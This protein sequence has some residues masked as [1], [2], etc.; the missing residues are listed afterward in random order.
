MSKYL[1]Q[2]LRAL[3]PAFSRKAAFGWFI[4]AFAGFVTRNDNYGVSSIV[5]ALWLSPICYQPLL[6]FFHSSAWTAE[7]LMV[8]WRMWLV[9]QNVAHLQGDRIILVGDH[10]KVVKDGR[11]MPEVETLHQDSETGSKPSYFRGHHWACISLLIRAKDKFFGAPLWAEIHRES[12]GEKRS[13]RIINQA[14]AMAQSLENNAYLVL[15]AFFAAGPVFLTAAH[16][17][18]QLLILTRAKK[19]VV[20]Y[21]VPVKEDD[22]GPGRPRQYGEKLKLMELFDSWPD[23]FK[24]AQSLVYGKVEDVRYLILDLIWKPVKGKLRFILI[25]SS[26]G[27]IILITSDMQMEMQAALN[28][29]CHRVTVETLF[30]SLKNLLGGMAY[31][32]WSKYL[33]PSSRRPT[34]NKKWKASSSCPHKTE[35]T[36]SAIEKFVAVQL[37]VLGTLQLLACLVGKEIHASARCWL[38]TP[39]G[40]IPSVFVTRNAVA[41]IIRGNLITFG[42]DWITQEI[43]GKQKRGDDTIE[44]D[45]HFDEAA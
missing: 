3:R 19:N 41:N 1:D 35:N 23:S 13:T 37:V 26:R 21:L 12:L 38:R 43:L 2:L 39:C 24:T 7:K 34:K 18:G 45:T 22:P 8:Q 9:K 36:L 14:G 42:K 10:T 4:V 33:E 11:K 32:F 20:A 27:R 31:H 29:Y 15:D 5:R 30:D 28:L 44:N 17:A 6:H 16:Y 40:E 25:E